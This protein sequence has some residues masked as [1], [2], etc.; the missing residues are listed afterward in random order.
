MGNNNY[1]GVL[2][3][4]QLNKILGWVVVAYLIVVRID[5][6]FCFHFFVEGNK[7]HS[8]MQQNEIIRISNHAK[9]TKRQAEKIVYRLIRAASSPHI[10]RPNFFIG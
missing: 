10:S 9:E 4:V 3:S 5:I 2:N 8:S 7:E 6:I 1:T